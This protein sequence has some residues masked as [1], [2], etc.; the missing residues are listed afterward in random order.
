VARRKVLIALVIVIVLAIVV[1]F[2]FNPIGH[3]QLAADRSR[4]EQALTTLEPGTPVDR[5]REFIRKQGMNASDLE[6]E[7]WQPAKPPTGARFQMRGIWPHHVP[8]FAG[9]TSFR[10][11]FWF[12]KDRRLIGTEMGSWGSAL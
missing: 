6:E 9:A 10:V 5:V 11:E 3:Y 8:H 7:F 4:V 12:D 2:V 1:H